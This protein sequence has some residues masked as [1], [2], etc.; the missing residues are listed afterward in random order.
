MTPKPKRSTQRESTKTTH[1]MEEMQS[2]TNSKLS[3]L[4]EK[5][6][7]LEASLLA[8]TQEKEILKVTVSRQAIEL[9]ELRNSLNEREQYARS[10]SMR[11]LN[12]P[13]PKESESD[14]RLVMQ[15]VYDNLIHPILEGARASGAIDSVPSCDS[16]LETA[17][18]LPGKTDG[19]K[20]VI[21]RFYSRYWRNLRFRNSREFAPREAS[22]TAAASTSSR[23]GANRLARMR[24]PFFEDLTKAN[25]Q[26]LAAIKQHEDVSSAWTVNGTIKFKIKDDDTIYRIS[27]LQESVEDVIS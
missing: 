20:L 23:S 15:S 21:A 14:T 1:S 18:I 8:V 27:N 11:V 5:F 2:E 17:H 4:I 26:K 13:V 3:E 12:V 16:L 24:F 6:E 7:Q 22:T 25:F 10:W 19:H 9:A